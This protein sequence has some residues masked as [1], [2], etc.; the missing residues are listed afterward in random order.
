LGVVLVLG[1]PDLGERFFAPGWA[2]LGSA[3]STLPILCHQHRCSRV[4][5]KHLADHGPEPQGT[6]ADREHR[7]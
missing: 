1:V 7:R 5:G 2:D 4:S 6:V 3:L